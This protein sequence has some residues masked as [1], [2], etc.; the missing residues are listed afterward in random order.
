VQGGTVNK[1]PISYFFQKKHR[2][3]TAGRLFLVEWSWKRKKW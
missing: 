2:G 1:V 3:K